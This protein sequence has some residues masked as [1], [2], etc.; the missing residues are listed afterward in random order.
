MIKVYSHYMYSGENIIIEQR[1]AIPFDILKG[2]KGKPKLK[3]CKDPLPGFQ[4]E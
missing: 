2:A 1:R 4:M 3:M